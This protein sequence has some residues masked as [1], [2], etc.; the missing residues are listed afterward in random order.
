MAFADDYIAGILGYSPS[1]PREP[2]ETKALIHQPLPPEEE[3]S[4][5]KKLL[6]YG[7]SALGFVGGQLD[8]F[9]GSRAIRGALAGKPRE[10]ASIL[11]MSDTLGIT[12][13]EDRTSGEELA[14]H[15]GLLDGEGQKGEFELRDLVG[16]AL[17]IGLDP[18]T[19]LTFGGSA[20]TKA[21]QAAKKLGAL[22]KGMAG[23]IR[24]FTAADD[25]A[26]AM[27]LGVPEATQL[28]GKVGL[29]INDLI[30]KPLGGMAGVRNFPVFG[31]ANPDAILGT[32][33]KSQKIA[34]KLADVGDTLTYSAPG[35]YVSAAVDPRVLGRTEETF[36][37]VARDQDKA[38]KVREALTNMSATGV[39]GDTIYD[40]A[41][42]GVNPDVLRSEIEKVPAPGGG[43]PYSPDVLQAASDVAG[44]FGPADRAKLNEAMAAGVKVSP[45]DSLYGIEHGSRQ[46]TPLPNE[47]MNW[48]PDQ[49]GKPGFISRLMGRKVNER[50][51][52]RTWPTF[53]RLSMFDV[54]GGT[55]MLNQM[56]R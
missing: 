50:M 27:G 20:L 21:G 55:P 47:P 6:G 46:L 9:T 2:A 13:E 32:G 23:R 4:Q 37:R 53:K 34:D 29:D 19:Y 12:N 39:A 36:Q 43:V 48:L 42:K 28:A 5:L 26:K 25:V 45:L 56:A 44:R 1:Q 41:F 18:T 22:P 17:E 24:G 30:G 51:N 7:T 35:R 11:P 54:P 14:K 49:S 3:Q 10:L 31:H 33:A 40:K 16:P 8:K 52:A 15:Y 38:S